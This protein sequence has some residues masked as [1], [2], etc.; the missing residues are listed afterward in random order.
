MRTI[1]LPALRQHVTLGAYMRAVRLAKANPDTT[2]K[3]GFTTWWPTTG[4]EI[5]DQFRE[6]MMHRINQAI[7]YIDRGK[8]R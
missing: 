2:F 1:Y 8:K 5:M 4:A 3:T 7:P 6:G